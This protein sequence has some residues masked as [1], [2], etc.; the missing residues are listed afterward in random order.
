MISADNTLYRNYPI[1]FDPSAYGR[2]AW[3]KFAKKYVEYILK[4]LSRI[5][6]KVDQKCTN[7]Y[8]TTFKRNWCKYCIWKCNHI[9]LNILDIINNFVSFLKKLV[10]FLNLI[11]RQTIST[12]GPWSIISHIDCNLIN[13]ISYEI[14]LICNV[15]FLIYDMMA[16]FLFFFMI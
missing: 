10:R 9:Y 5:I 3:Y 15:Q 13:E 16:M 4:I 6:V 1:I 12:G 11:Q 7:G 14:S 2:K 8:W